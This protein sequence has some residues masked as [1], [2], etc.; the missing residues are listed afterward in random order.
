MPKQWRLFYALPIQME[1]FYWTVIDAVGIAGIY[2]INDKVDPFLSNSSN[3]CVNIQN[4]ITD[5][6]I[7]I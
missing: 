4:H 6:L 7:S 1:L 5:M 2:L 3:V